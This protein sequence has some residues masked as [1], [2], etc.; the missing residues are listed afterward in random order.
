MALCLSFAAVASYSATVWSSAFDFDGTP[1]TE[2]IEINVNSPI[3]YSTEL[4]DNLTYC[5]ATAITITATSQEHP[6]YVADIYHNSSLP[7][8][9]FTGTAVW[10]FNDSQYNTFPKNDTYTLKEEITTDYPGTTTLTRTITLA[11]EPSLIV[12]LGLIGA[13]LIR[14]RI[15]YVL[16]VLLLA[17]IGSFNAWAG[18]TITSVTCQQ[19]WPL[20]RKVLITFSF[21]TDSRQAINFY[22][23]TDNGATSFE[24]SEKGTLV[25]AA[26][27]YSGSGTQTIVWEPDST[28]D[29]VKGKIKIGVEIG[30]PNYLVI[31][32]SKGSTATYYQYRYI[33]S[34]PP[35]GWTDTYKKTKMALSLVP[36]GTFSMGSPSGEAGR[37]ASNETQHQ[38]TLTQPFYAGVFEVTQEQY[39]LVTGSYSPSYDGMT[40]TKAAAGI[41]YDDIRGSEDGKYWPE[42]DD[43]D[44]GSF[45]GKL[46][47]KCSSLRFDLPTEAQWEYACRATTTKA[48]NS[49]ENLEDPYHTYGR[50]SKMDEVGYADRTGGTCIVGQFRVNDWGLYDMHGNAGEWCLDW[51]EADLGSTAKTNPAGPNRNSEG[52]RVVRGGNYSSEPAECRSASRTGYDHSSGGSQ[53]NYYYGFRV[54]LIKTY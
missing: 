22:G 25:G 26:Q 41:S 37:D 38:V 45:L 9:P 17:T 36:A 2:P 15:K 51:Y 21:T 24:L 53:G 18:G 30:D 42:E 29:S 35:G 31:D 54:V 1:T 33:P 44:A 13:L 3:C 12:A 19:A 52:K 5:D 47:K 43:V 10:D 50:D 23:T 16:A 6:V 34:V 39:K 14:R 32:L 8:G 46:R 4:R 7:Q 20:S 49:D 27:H 28:F 48:L 40:I 11:P